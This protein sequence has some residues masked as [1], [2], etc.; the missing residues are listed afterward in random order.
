MFG[1]TREI[2]HLESK[3]AFI[4]IFPKPALWDELMMAALHARRS[5]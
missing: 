1:D 4:A 3:L 5:A 2:A